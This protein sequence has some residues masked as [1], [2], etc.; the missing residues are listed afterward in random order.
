MDLGLTENEIDRLMRWFDPNMTGK[1]MYRE[2]VDKLMG[3]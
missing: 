3:Q 1:I 2:F